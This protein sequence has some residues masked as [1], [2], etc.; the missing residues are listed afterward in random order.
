VERSR[1]AVANVLVLKTAPCR[2]RNAALPFLPS[3]TVYGA[4]LET[5]WDNVGDPMQPAMPQ[6]HVEGGERLCGR[7]SRLIL[8]EARG[9]QPAIPRSLD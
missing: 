5:V 3:I 2:G 7:S 9:H 6:D 4:P 1:L 8:V